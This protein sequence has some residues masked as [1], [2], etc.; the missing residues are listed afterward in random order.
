MHVIARKKLA[1]FWATEPK[2]EQPLSAW[3]HAVEAALWSNFGDVRQTFNTAD[4]VRH[5]TIFDIGGNKYR[6]IAFVDYQFSAV[7]V[8]AVLT[9]K[10]F[11]RGAWQSDDF[12]SKPHPSRKRV[13]GTRKWQPK[14]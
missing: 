10:E 14:R 3:F 2:A 4:R 9:H 6:L 1:E 11:Q 13:K 5:L 12:G 7:F 8:R